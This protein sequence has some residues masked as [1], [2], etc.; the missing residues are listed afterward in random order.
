SNARLPDGVAT[1]RTA[2]S[3]LRPQLAVQAARQHVAHPPG[4]VLSKVFVTGGA[5]AV[6]GDL[7]VRRA[8]ETQLGVVRA[9][10]QPA[11]LALGAKLP[12]RVVVLTHARLAP[13]RLRQLPAAAAQEHAASDGHVGQTAGAAERAQ[14]EARGLL[15]GAVR[16]ASFQHHATLLVR[17]NR[18]QALWQRSSEQIIDRWQGAAHDETR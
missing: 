5:R 13:R 3:V 1:E 18:H 15:D 12:A 10:Q 8:P 16:E 4:G 11:C 9:T 14:L 2:R 7:I 6:E 17:R